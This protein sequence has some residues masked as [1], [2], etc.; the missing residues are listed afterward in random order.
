MK[1]QERAQAILGEFMDDYFMVGECDGET[2][3]STSNV[4][5][6]RDI[7]KKMPNIIETI[8]EMESQEQ[9]DCDDRR[10]AGRDEG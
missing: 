10:E 4:K 9:E 3:V 5:Y 8:D 7:I 6:A 1:P 2:T